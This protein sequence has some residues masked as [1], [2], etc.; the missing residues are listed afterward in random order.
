MLQI[1]TGVELLWRVIHEYQHTNAANYLYFSKFYTN[2]RLNISSQRIRMNTDHSFHFFPDIIWIRLDL[3]MWTAESSWF[4]GQSIQ[5]PFA[6]P[7]CVNFS[8][9]FPGYCWTVFFLRFTRIWVNSGRHAG[10]LI[11]FHDRWRAIRRIASIIIFYY[12]EGNRN[13]EQYTCIYTRIQVLMV[14]KTWRKK[15]TKIRYPSW[16]NS[17]G[18]VQK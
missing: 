12:R 17:T 13:H 1:D 15:K 9:F 7:I 3:T 18:Y 16:C 11:E 6:M 2:F 10:F 14:H 4:F 8:C 5:R